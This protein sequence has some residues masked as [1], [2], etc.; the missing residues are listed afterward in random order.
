M[1]LN[2]IYMD[3]NESPWI[4]A[5]IKWKATKIQITTANNNYNFVLC[6]GWFNGKDAIVDLTARP[7]GLAYDHATAC[8]YSLC[9][10]IVHI[11]D[12]RFHFS[13][14]EHFI[15]CW[16]IF[17]HFPSFCSILSSYY[18]DVVHLYSFIIFPCP[19]SNFFLVL[20]Y[21][22]YLKDSSC[23]LFNNLRTQ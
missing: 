20:P 19:P 18:V 15:D 10:H 2:H 1:N 5:K 12:L 17:Q 8:H 16:T 13:F 3:I 14:L 22:S 23:F 4:G 21:G 9:G 11:F 6:N 7:N